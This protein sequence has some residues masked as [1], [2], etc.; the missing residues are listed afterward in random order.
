MKSKRETFIN[1]CAEITGY[2]GFDLEGTGNV[3][4]FQQLMEAVLGPQL[5]SEFYQLAE[6]V[7]CV[8]DPANRENT[9]RDSFSPRSKF[10]PVVS[11]LIELWYLGV[12]TQLPDE[13]YAATGLPIPGPND[14]GRTHTPSALAYIEQLSYRAADAHTPGAKPTGFGSWSTRPLL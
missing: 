8:D 4:T 9:I 13:W 1:F 7:V 14:S 12:W 6:D 3:D 5:A 11:S 10:W 2:S